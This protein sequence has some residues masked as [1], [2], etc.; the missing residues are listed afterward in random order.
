M[1]KELIF[2]RVVVPAIPHNG[3]IRFLMENDQ[4][5]ID[6]QFADIVWKIISQANG[7][8]DIKEISLQTQIPYNTVLAV[9]NDLM[10]L[11]V[12]YNSRDYYLYFHKLSGSPDI[13]PQNL[14]FEDVLKLQNIP[15]KRKKGKLLSFIA[16]DKSELSNLIFGRR[17]CR[18]FKA[19]K[20]S[21][22][23]IS[24][25]CFHGYSITKHTVPSGGALYP[26]TLYVI[27]TEDQDELPSGYYEYDSIEDG[28]RCYQSK[29][30]IEQLKY[31]YN[32]VEL[33][34]NSSVQIVI[35]ADLSRETKKYSN[36]GYRLTL[37]EAGQVAQNISLY[38][39]KCKL[40]SCELGG[41][42]DNELAQELGLENKA[43]LLTIAV[44]VPETDDFNHK[45]D[46]LAFESELRN[47]YVG[48]DKPIKYSSGHYLGDGASF[49]GA[50]SNYGK[51]D[52]I[53]GA[54]S[55]SCAMAKAKA[56]IEGY[57][58]YICEHPL[59]ELVCPAK[60]LHCEWLD[61]KSV[62]PTSE[63]LIDSSE[64]LVKFTDTLEIAWKKGRYLISNKQIFVPVDLIY[65]G[66]YD[67][68]NRICYST[69]SGVAAHTNE[70]DAIK[71]AL[72]ELIERDALMRNWYER[73]T[74]KR[75][76]DKILPV[77]VQKRIAKW[78]KSNRDVIILDMGSIYAPTVQ[79]I[80]VSED[81]PCFVCGASSGYD[82]ESS[83]LKALQEA[84]YM[85]YSFMKQ[86][87]REISPSLVWTPID[88][89]LLYATKKYINNIKWLWSNNDMITTIPCPQYSYDK[90]IHILDPI[91]VNM[92][93]DEKIK[94]VRVL[95]KK[96]LPINFGDSYNLTDHPVM[97]TL[98]IDPKSME[99]PH[100]F[101]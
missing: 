65:Y 60:S 80:I 46:C 35:T 58:R 84:E 27:V 12:M 62:N 37:I 88:H 26:I 68:P 94:V 61:P 4:I 69:S 63:K 55:T 54:T 41:V 40:G 50:Y 48:E 74:P 1:E 9:I 59:Y 8:N 6:D 87:I 78:K 82:V 81:Y 22:D 3:G 43:P 85:L 5:D 42:L 24:N 7:H 45:I 15:R 75:F 28:L 86:P 31:C 97:K 39:E 34:F 90:L 100:Y 57:E 13:Y 73:K 67:L 19:A 2:P 99:L 16:D 71:N 92:T 17:S 47:N 89:G 56:I 32:D 93:T 95:S 33:P 23:I 18:N 36:R 51:K 64:E 96:C 52:D 10:K 30:D 98:N 83:I 91:V 20:L 72:M 25:I 21:C 14:S 79:V 77:H 49:F 70:K 101:A 53:A 29:I 38:C 11:G 44:G 66:S 76:D